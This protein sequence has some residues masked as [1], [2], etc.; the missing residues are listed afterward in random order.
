MSTFAA[1]TSS[2]A[3]EL[4]AFI[5]YAAQPRRSSLSTASWSARREVVRS[6]TVTPSTF[7][8]RAI[9]KNPFVSVRSARVFLRPVRLR[10]GLHPTLLSLPS[11]SNLFLE[12]FCG[13][14]DD[15]CCRRRG[16][17]EA[18][19]AT[20]RGWLH[21]DSVMPFSP[22]EV[23]ASGDRDPPMLRGRLPLPPV[24]MRRYNNAMEQWE[25]TTF[26][27]KKPKK[28]AVDGLARLGADGWEA[29][30]MV[31]SWGVGWSWVH[32]IVLLKRP[33]PG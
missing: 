19:P 10:P 23:E 9:K 1:W 21:S 14:T 17:R 15:W 20:F 11:T 33:L 18:L 5:R 3:D 25:Y 29:V 2:R 12:I 27:M 22:R 13:Y 30:A 16:H 32:P 28:D 26:D 31:S 24:W 8:S 4:A 7:N 6:G